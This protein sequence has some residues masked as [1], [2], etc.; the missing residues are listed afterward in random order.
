MICRGS[1]LMSGVTP[2]AYDTAG[3]RLA[4]MCIPSIELTNA[5]SAVDADY[6]YGYDF[7]DIGNRKTSAERG[8]NSVYTASQLN[9]YTAVDDFT[10][11]YDADGNQTVVKTATGTWQVSYNGENRPR[12][13]LGKVNTFRPRSGKM[14]CWSSFLLVAM[15]FARA[16]FAAG[17]VVPPGGISPG[18]VQ[19]GE[20]KAAES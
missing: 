15:A 10:P 14:M 19:P 20:V 8:T 13:V 9:Q 7:D 17:L 6:R 1:P 18:E 4:S 5:T 2:L 12:S 16:A 3:G 11:T